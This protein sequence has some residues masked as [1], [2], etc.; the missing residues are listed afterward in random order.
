MDF[1]N[2]LVDGGLIAAA[3]GAMLG[4]SGD[5]EQ[6]LSALMHGL[7]MLGSGVLIWLRVWS[8]IRRENKNQ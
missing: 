6:I 1:K 4:Q 5:V 3:C 7:I 2:L 8:F